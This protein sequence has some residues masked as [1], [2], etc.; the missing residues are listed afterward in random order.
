MLLVIVGLWRLLFKRNLLYCISIK[1]YYHILVE[2]LDLHF[3]NNF[4][5]K[6]DEFE[7]NTIF[8][9]GLMFFGNQLNPFL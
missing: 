7:L 1:G 6:D 2:Y 5:P 9:L 8:G 4:F 3:H